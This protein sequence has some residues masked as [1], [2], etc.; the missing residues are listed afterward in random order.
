MKTIHQ[1]DCHRTCLECLAGIRSWRAVWEKGPQEIRIMANLI[2]AL[3]LKLFRPSVPV[4]F[5]TDAEGANLDD[6]GYRSSRSTG[7]ARRRAA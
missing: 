3:E 6:I 5:A 2:P 1:K 7:L 4:A